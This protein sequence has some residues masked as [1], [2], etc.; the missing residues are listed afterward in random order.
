MAFL[1]LSVERPVTW[2]KMIFTG[3]NDLEKAWWATM[4]PV[5]M[6]VV[7]SISLNLIGDELARRFDIREAAV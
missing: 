7:T 3:T 1:G 2:G 5:M 4:F 6:V